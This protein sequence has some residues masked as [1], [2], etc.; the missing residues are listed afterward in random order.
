MRRTGILAVSLAA[1]AAV[2]QA[3]AQ[4]EKSDRG[5]LMD[6]VIAVVGG[7]V[8]TRS[9]LGDAMTYRAT[10]LKA[11]EKAGLSREEVEK[12][13][14]VMQVEI[15]DNLVENKLI[16]LAGREDGQSAQDEVKRR[17]EKLKNGLGS[18]PEKLKAYAAQQ[19]FASYEEFEHQMEEE[20]L[21]QRVVFTQ[22]R[23]KAEVSEKELDEAYRNRY[24][25][26][27]AQEAGCD[28]AWVRVFSLE[29]VRFPLAS[30]TTVGGLVETYAAAYRCYG[31]LAKGTFG[32]ADAAGSCLAPAGVP[33]HGSL[34]DIDETKSFEKPFQQAFDGLTQGRDDKFSEPFVLNDG[35]WILHVSAEHRECF[36]DEAELS[37]L[38]DRLRGKLEEE[39]FE[40]ALKWWLRQLRGHYR[41]ELM[42][43]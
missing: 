40:R 6:S 23:P 28:G 2:S 42:P 33:F 16:V 18:D 11:R 41:V 1:L 9:E 26:K 10:L 4:S 36:T 3:A 32:M 34:G 24:A 21:R 43:L 7:E 29:Q 37:R 14:A 15:R 27:P 20:Y 5:L 17:M 22:V 8:V 12:E 35:V 25:G 39:K 38:K 13:F 31:E 19:G 30:G